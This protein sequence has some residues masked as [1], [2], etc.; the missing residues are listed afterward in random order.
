MR[1]IRADGDVGGGTSSSSSTAENSRFDA[2]QYSFFGKAPLDGL[3]LGGL[4]DDGGVEGYGGGFGGHDDGAY[5]LSPVGEEIDCMSNLSEIDDLAST[6]AKLNRTISGTR[7]PGVIGDRRSISRESSLTNDWVPEADFPNWVDLDILN[8]DEFQDR[9]QLCAQPQYLPQFGES[10]PLSRTSSYPLEPLQHRSSEPILG[11]IS[12]SFTSYPPPGGGE[13][14]YPAQGLTLHSSIPSPGAGH[15]MGSKSSSLSGSPYNMTSVPHGLRYGRSMSYT[16]AD[17]SA[18]NFLQNEWPNQA[19]PHTFE[20]FNQRPSLLQPQLSYPGSSMSS[21]LFSQQQQRSPLVPPSHHNYLNLQPQFY[22]HHSPEMIGKFDHVPNLPS[23]RDKRSRSG[24]GKHSIRFSQQPSDTAGQ[25]VD[26]G[27]IKFRSKYMSSEEIESILRMQ[28][29]TSHSSDPYI[30][31]YY[32]QA[33][34]AKRSASSQ[35]K[36]N[37]SPMS[38]KDFPSKSRSGGD[39]HSYLQVDAVGRVSF[40]SIRRP[41]PLLEVDIPASGDHKSSARPL[42]K[43]PMLAARITVEDGISLLLNVN[44]IDRFLQS[45][46]AQ[47]SSLQLRRRRQVL[48]EGLA[49]SLELVDPFGP[50]KPGNSSGLAP[51]DDLIFLRIVSLP[52]GRKLLARYLRLLVPGSELTRIVCMAIFRHLRSLFGG[53]ASDSGA[54]ETTVGLAKTVSSCV[55]HMELS[56]LSACLAAVVCSSQQPPLRPLGSSAGD[57]ASL[58]IKSVLD[59]ATELLADPHSAADYSRSTRSLWQASFDAFFGLLTKYCDSKYGSI[60][61][62]FSMQGSNSIARSEASKAVSREMPVE[63]L[64]ASLPHTNEQQRQMLLDFARK[65]MPVTGFN[66]SGASSGHFTSESVAG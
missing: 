43:E 5:Q 28:H 64:R 50:N 36:I 53:L 49:T 62:M 31:D 17:L 12:P 60:L 22:H 48:L 40:S 14:S 45:S 23:P 2:A 27:G 26:N 39:Q 33:C 1:G 47:D 4:V 46:Q 21:L 59:R 51:T 35:Q 65:S 11:H 44:D 30:D 61:Q 13:L 24:R 55:Q 6:F 29:S 15:Q 16:A 56:A 63:L 38:I 8:N 58:I 25:N 52:K 19:G 9:K 7:N 20:H 57:G 54:A 32:H 3:E 37:F 42:E 10:K 18:N 41:R 66:H 34:I